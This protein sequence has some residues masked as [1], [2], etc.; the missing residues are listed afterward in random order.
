MRLTP[1]WNRGSAATL[2]TMW[3]QHEQPRQHPGG[4]PGFCQEIPQRDNPARRNCGSRYRSPQR[5]ATLRMLD[6]AVAL[7]TL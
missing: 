6:I 3:P 2:L 4:Q 1:G 7:P 5:I